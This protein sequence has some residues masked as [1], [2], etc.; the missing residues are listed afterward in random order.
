V[1]SNALDSNGKFVVGPSAQGSCGG[2]DPKAFLYSLDSYVSSMAVSISVVFYVFSAIE[3]IVLS[4]G[5]WL[6]FCASRATLHAV[7]GFDVDAKDEVGYRRVARVR[8]GINARAGV[9]GVAHW[10]DRDR[11]RSALEWRLKPRGS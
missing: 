5:L 11:S 1:L 8:C 6:L 7:T 10:I 4:F 9:G 2:G 3:I